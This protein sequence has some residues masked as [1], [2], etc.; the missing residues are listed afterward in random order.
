MEV[1]T[2]RELINLIE[3]LVYQKIAKD[4][5]FLRFSFYEIRVKGRVGEKQEGEFLRLAQ[6]K[7]NN[8]GYAVYFQEQEFFYNEAKMKVQDNELIIAIK[9][10]RKGC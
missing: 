2:E 5:N 1:L 7:L 6:N 8:M 3:H 10:N 9:N 4:E